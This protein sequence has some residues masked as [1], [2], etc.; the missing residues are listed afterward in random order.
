MK[1]VFKIAVII[2][3]FVLL[4]SSTYVVFYTDSEEME[5]GDTDDDHIDNE[6]D[7]DTED[8][9]DDEETDD[10]DED[11]FVTEHTVF[12][13]EATY[14]T[15]KNCPAIG[16]ILHEL[17]ESPDYNIYYVSL[18]LD[19]AEAKKRLEQEYNTW[20]YPTVYIDGG[21]EV[22]FGKKDKSVVVDRI[23]KALSR[24]VPAVYVNV[25]ANWNVNQGK[26]NIEVKVKNNDSDTYTGFLRVY[27]AEIRSTR[28]NDYNVDPYHFGFLEF[29]IDE[30]LE[31]SPY[32]MENFTKTMDDSGFDPENLMIFAVVF[33]SESVEKY[34]DPKKDAGRDSHPFDAYYAD[35]ADATRVLEGSL[36]S[37]IGITQPKKGMH[38]LPGKEPSKSLLGKTIIVGPI[39]IKTNVQTEAGVEKVE[40][41][42]K[43]L[44][45][46]A[47]ETVT[48]EPYEWTWDKLALGR[49]TITVKLYDTEGK[50]A[51]D[52]IDVLALIY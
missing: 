4:I 38:Y 10:E 39:T 18:I 33:N 37:T 1:S 36:P 20:G 11:D 5:S 26:I 19:E 6:T 40:F 30:S 47:T 14:T 29:A 27:L 21:Y 52:S 31:I 42:I 25:S 32:Q 17:Y 15:C 35:A 16:D 9:N 12:I 8:N 28:W 7:D 46:E 3:A 48:S 22:I 34:S 51:T 44:L 23:K 41:T 45:G 24:D 49:Y 50:T 13:E 43:G 2:V